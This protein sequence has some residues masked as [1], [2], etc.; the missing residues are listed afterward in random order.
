MYAMGFGSHGGDIVHIVNF[1]SELVNRG[2]AYRTIN[3]S[4]STISVGHVPI[5]DIPV[6]EHP[7]VGT[8]LRRIQL[9]FRLQ[10]MYTSLWGVNVVLQLLQSW[11]DNAYL[12]C[13]EL[14]GR[15]VILLCLISCKWVSEVCGLDISARIFTTEG[16]SFTIARHT[17]SNTRVV[18]YLS[19]MVHPKLCVVRCLRV[20]ES[21][22]EDYRPPGTAQLFILL[23][24]PFKPVLVETIARWERLI[25]PEAGTDTSSF[26]AHSIRGDY[27]L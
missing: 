25:L 4:R 1:L 23:K 24:K 2:M 12:S 19:F 17:K 8:L 9:S 22:M 27:G 16:V 18:H 13:K 7:L 15:L 10:L 14:T 3:D 26:G 20:Y 6:G 5:H 11:Q 21:M